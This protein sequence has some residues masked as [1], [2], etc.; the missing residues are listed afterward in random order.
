MPETGQ[1]MN[2]SRIGIHA[3]LM[4]I[5]LISFTR[6]SPLLAQELEPRIYN[7]IPVGLNFLLAGYAYTA[8]G[9]QF[10]PSLPLENANMRTHGA[11]MAY[12]RSVKLGG[13]VWKSGYGPALCL[14]VWFCRLPG[15]TRHPGGLWPG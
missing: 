11:L 1:N 14:V 7:N 2:R 12:A 5:V 9:I 10:D 15:A 13:G 6:A 8:G 4:F 3:F